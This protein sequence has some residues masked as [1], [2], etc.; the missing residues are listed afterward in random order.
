MKEQLGFGGG[1]PHHIEITRYHSL[2]LNTYL[3]QTAFP[4]EIIAGSCCNGDFC[5]FPFIIRL[6]DSS[7][8]QIWAQVPEDICAIEVNYC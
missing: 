1:S 3:C 6:N 2:N 4:S 5:A 7:L 8:L